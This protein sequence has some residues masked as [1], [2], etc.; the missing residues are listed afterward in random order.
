MSGNGLDPWGNPLPVGPPT[1]PP[2][3][4]PPAPAANGAPVGSAD[5]WGDTTAPAPEGADPGTGRA[6]RNPAAGGTPQIVVWGLVAAIAGFL[7]CG[8]FLGPAAVFMGISGRKRVRSTGAPGEGLAVAAIVLG[9]ICF[10]VNVVVIVV[11][12]SNPDLAEQLGV[13][14]M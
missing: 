2:T 10:V 7:I 14:G 4:P 13:E 11:I 5:W 6:P 9:V 12:L 3:A 8:V 1:Q